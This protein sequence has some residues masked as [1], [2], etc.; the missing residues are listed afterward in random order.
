MPI[1]RLCSVARIGRRLP[2]AA[3]VAEIVAM[4]AHV[5][6]YVITDGAR[7]VAIPETV[8]GRYTRDLMR[9][10][11][12]ETRHRAQRYVR[13]A[14]RVRAI[15]DLNADGSVPGFGAAILDAGPL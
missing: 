6:R 15:A 5:S 14:E 12:F 8:A 13:D 11:R 4:V 1:L 9:A 10:H 2:V 3:V 7:F